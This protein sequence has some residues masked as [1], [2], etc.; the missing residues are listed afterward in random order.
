MGDTRIQKEYKDILSQKEFKVWLV[1]NSFRHWK[2]IING[3]ED[4]VYHGGKFQLDIVIPDKYPY[5]PPKMKFDTNIWHPN[6][7]S[8]TGAIC[9][10]ILKD[11]WSPALSIRT[12]LLSIQALMWSPE[13]DNPQDAVVA[14]Q[15]KE[16]R[17][18][19]DK[20]AREWTEKY[21]NPNLIREKQIE[22]IVEMGF[23]KELAIEALEAVGWDESA[24]INSLVN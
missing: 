8:V 19:F 11:E 21:A 15:F 23:S 13:P 17:E 7:S 24:A 9:L 16:K 14:K 10:D 2:A 20:T 18:E 6:M 3:P 5:V 1:N 4:S 12:A 22:K